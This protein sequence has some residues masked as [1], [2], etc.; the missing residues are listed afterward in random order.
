MDTAPTYVWTLDVTCTGMPDLLRGI[1]TTEECATKA[2]QQIEGP[3]TDLEWNRHGD[4]MLFAR[5]YDNHGYI[6]IGWPLNEVE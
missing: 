2:A 6:V 1:F 5:P 3:D 4:H